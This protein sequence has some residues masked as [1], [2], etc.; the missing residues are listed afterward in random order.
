MNFPQNYGGKLTKWLLDTLKL[1]HPF[2]LSNSIYSEPKMLNNA[3]QDSKSDTNESDLMF[4]NN[5]LKYLIK[6]LFIVV[7]N[8]L[9]DFLVPHL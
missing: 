5:L 1:Q 9:S 7:N 3:Q 2:V 8:D 4:S 6:C